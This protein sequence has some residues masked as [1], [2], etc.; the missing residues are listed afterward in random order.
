VVILTYP[1]LAFGLRVL[2]HPQTGCNFV[3]IKE[4]AVLN[5]NQGSGMPESLDRAGNFIGNLWNEHFE[6]I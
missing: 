6:I 1:F 3:G 2:I 5:L 4:K